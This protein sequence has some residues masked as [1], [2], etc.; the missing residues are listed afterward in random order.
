MGTLKTYAILPLFFPIFLLVQ[1]PE[2]N[3]VTQ[4]SLLQSEAIQGDS[5]YNRNSQIGVA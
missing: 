2:T 4:L 1:T 3:F 5:D